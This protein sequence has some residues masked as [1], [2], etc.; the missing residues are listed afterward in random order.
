MFQIAAMIRIKKIDKKRLMMRIET[1]FLLMSPSN[2]VKN[3][4]TAFPANTR[5][6]SVKAS[7]T[8]D[9]MLY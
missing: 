4:V 2:L 7:K 9:L 5:I 1:R 6:S 3:R 8:K